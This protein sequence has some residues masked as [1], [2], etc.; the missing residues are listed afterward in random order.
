MSRGGST[1]SRVP[2]EVGEPLSALRVWVLTEGR[3]GDDGQLLRLADALGWECTALA[4]AGNTNWHLVLDRLRDLLGWGAPPVRL[5]ED[6]PDEWPDLVLAIAGRSVSTVRRIVTASGG[7]T[8]SVHLGRPV[9][10]LGSFDL[11]VT[12]PQYGLPA[13]RNVVRTAL[14]FAPPARPPVGT[15]EGTPFGGLPRPWTAVLVGGDSGSYRV[16]AASTQRL[17]AACHKATA[18]GGSVLVTTSPRTPEAV[19]RAL[20]DALPERGYF[21]AFARDDPDNPYAALLAFAD[22]F[23]VTGESASLIAEAAAM[24]R[25]VEVVPVEERPLAGLLVRGHRALKRSPLGPLLDRLCARGLWVP[26]RD[27]EA[28]HSAFVARG[29]AGSGEAELETVLERIREVVRGAPRARR[30]A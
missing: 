25:P 2:Q 26:P 24:E 23:V 21:Y 17:I 16:G 10:D 22:R 27:L 12:T 20:Q 30:R 9:A 13:G 29:Q 11:V 5:P 8:R 3:A 1:L 18:D 7:A 19:G 14:P 4:L 28:L 6:A 15:P